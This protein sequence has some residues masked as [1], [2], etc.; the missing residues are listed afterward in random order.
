MSA[1]SSWPGLPSPAWTRPVPGLQPAWV[2]GSLS[3]GPE[4]VRP[5]AVGWAAHPW[6]GG[7]RSA[8]PED[9]RPPAPGRVGHLLAAGRTLF[10][11]SPH[12]M[13]SVERGMENN[14]TRLYGDLHMVYTLSR[15]R[16]GAVEV[17]VKTCHIVFLSP[18]DT[19]HT[20]DS[21]GRA[22]VPAFA[23]DPGPEVKSGGGGGAACRFSLKSGDSTAT[24][25]DVAE[26]LG[27]AAPPSACRLGDTP[28][29]PG[30]AMEAPSEDGRPCSPPSPPPPCSAPL[31]ALS[32]AWRAARGGGW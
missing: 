10:N 26:S 25:A 3:A 16:K 23:S 18:F 7:P 6:V 19:R 21:V 12:C 8:G 11:P 15:E 32:H 9:L 13:P 4:G 29:P 24:P 14:V 27:G 17:T 20:I 2:G 1:P 5:P 31:A 22:S 30:S 28:L